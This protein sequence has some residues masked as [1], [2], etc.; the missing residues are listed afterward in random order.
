MYT[1]TLT[2]RSSSLVVASSSLTLLVIAH[3]LTPS[4]SY[5]FNPP[6]EHHT[7]PQR[8]IA[9]TSLARVPRHA[10]V[11]LLPL[12]SSIRI[13]SRHRHSHLFRTRARSSHFAYL[14][15]IS[16]TKNQ[17]TPCLH[18][19]YFTCLHL[20]PCLHPTSYSCLF[21]LPSPSTRPHLACLPP[22]SSSSHSIYRRHQPI[23]YDGTIPHH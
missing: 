19:A 18:L 7:I 20:T 6:S 22:S 21:H 5:S 4:Y 11:F 13:A 9:V 8:R 1:V 14:I 3:L 12:D 16:H 23:S 2:A 17:S 10:V 15:P